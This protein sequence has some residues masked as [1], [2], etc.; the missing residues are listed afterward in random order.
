[1][2]N[3]ITELFER[4]FENILSVFFTAGF[5]SLDDTRRIII[6]LEKSGVDMIEIGIPFSDPLADG[7]VIQKSSE[8]ALKNGMTLSILFEQLKEIRK[9][10]KIPLLLMGYLN[11]VMQYG[12]ENF[13]LKCRE[14]GIDGVILPDL[15]P[16]I[17]RKE[18]KDLYEKNSLSNIFLITPE[19]QSERIKEIDS[20]AGGFIYLVSSSSTTGGK[21]SF[22]EAKYKKIKE[23]GLQ[24]PFLVGFG[25][26]NAENFKM[27][28]R[29]ANGSIIGSAFINA[30]TTGKHEENIPAFISSILN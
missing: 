28:N 13:V 10:V 6:L 16:D 24:N 29:Y 17:Y 12:M 11:P 21:V 30:I 27:A 22:D 15:P 9:E 18:Y 4:K 14:T 5:P 19:T 20:I 7:P 2:K 1:M 23:M 3:R 26:S 25:I 8:Q